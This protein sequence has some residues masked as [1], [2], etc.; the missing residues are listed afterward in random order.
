MIPILYEATEGLYTTGDNLKGKSIIGIGDGLLYG[1]GLGAYNSWL[2]KLSRQYSMSA[3]NL[4]IVGSSIAKHEQSAFKSVVERI[5]TLTDADII[6]VEGGAN[7]KTYNVPIGNIQDDDVET[8]CG[9]INYIIDYI[10]KKIQINNSEN[11]NMCNIFS[12]N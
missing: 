9:A 8:F 4:G 3:T 11:I 12:I 6:V 1:V 10:K 5:T 7:D 2:N